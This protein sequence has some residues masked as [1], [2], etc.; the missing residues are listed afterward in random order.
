MA[1]I[2]AGLALI[3]IVL[4][5][6]MV[7]IDRHEASVAEGMR[8]WPSTTATVVTSGLHDE[9]RQDGTWIQFEDATFRYSVNGHEYKTGTSRY[10]GLRQYEHHL[11][12]QP[13]ETVRV[14]YDP[15]QPSSASLTNDPPVPSKVMLLIGALCFA[16]S[17]PFFYISARMLRK[18]P[19]SQ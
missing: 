16:L 1:A 12:Y 17:L 7:A 5:T 13:N 11:H 15:A 3:L 14:Y 10:A 18:R 6:M 9:R 8:S 2:P 4:G 19:H